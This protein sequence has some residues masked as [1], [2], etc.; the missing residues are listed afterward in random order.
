MPQNAASKMT[1]TSYFTQ[2]NELSTYRIPVSS[3]DKLLYNYTSTGECHVLGVAIIEDYSNQDAELQDKKQQV[4]NQ[5]LAKK[6]LDYLVWRHPLLRAHLERDSRK[7]DETDP[8]DSDLRLVISNDKQ[9]LDADNSKHLE[10]KTAASRNDLPGLL[11]EFNVAPYHVDAR[12]LDESKPWRLCW[13]EFNEDSRVKY[14]VAFSLPLYL[15]DGL[16]ISALLIEYINTLNSILLDQTCQ[17]MSERLDLADVVHTLV[18]KKQLIDGKKLEKIKQLPNREL[19]DSRIHAKFREKPE[20]GCKIN[21]FCVDE[22]VTKR[23]LQF[24]KSHNLK[25]T[26]YLSAILLYAL[27]D[28]YTENGLPFP[29]DFFFGLAA[30]LR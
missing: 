23:C 2:V 11:V 24:C 5:Q 19:P 8:F 22:L 25:L 16:C 30:N 10:W 21:M 27:E 20:R 26:G 29:S 3:Y 13:I 12:V 15:C 28:L 17:E 18:K 7:S 4:V 6:A 9:S 14:A 1:E